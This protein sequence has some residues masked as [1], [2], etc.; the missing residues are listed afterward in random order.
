MTEQENREKVIEEM[1]KIAIP[2][3]KNT[4][5]YCDGGCMDNFNATLFYDAGY[6]KIIPN[7]DFVLR[8]GDISSIIEKARKE[9]IKEVVEKTIFPIIRDK[10]SPSV[11]VEFIKTAVLAKFGVEV[12]E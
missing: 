4:C 11:Q 10:Y 7:V 5:K 3:C 12:E 8:A 2:E 6:R 1:S 9:A